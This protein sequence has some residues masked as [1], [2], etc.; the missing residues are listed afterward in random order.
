LT[1]VHGGLT[2]I[3]KIIYLYINKSMVAKQK[4][5]LI[6]AFISFTLMAEGIAQRDGGG[7]DDWSDESYASSSEDH[8]H[9][10]CTTA[11]GVTTCAPPSSSSFN[12]YYLYAIAILIILAEV[13]LFKVVNKY[14]LSRAANK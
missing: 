2:A 8:L 1:K 13:F 7:V 9:Q 4:H 3:A 6:L 11:N 12:Q 5:F 10:N 14:R